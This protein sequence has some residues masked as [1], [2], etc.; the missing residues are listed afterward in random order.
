MF[1]SE[2]EKQQLKRK[3]RQKQIEFQEKMRQKLEQYNSPDQNSPTSTD[4]LSL[5]TVQWLGITCCF[6]STV[7]IHAN[8]LN[9][10]LG[11]PL[12]GH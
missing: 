2:D 4:Y 12:N 6:S 11:N 10:P 3:Q 7:P 9:N 5:Y 8:Q 1:F